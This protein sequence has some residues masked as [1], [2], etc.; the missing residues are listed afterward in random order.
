MTT[1][2][3]SRFAVTVTG[4]GRGRSL[5]TVTGEVGSEAADTFRET[6]TAALDAGSGLDVD[7]S[8]VS[9]C[10]AST[11]RVLTEAFTRARDAGR[12]LA[13]VAVSPPVAGQLEL[14]GATGLLEQRAPQDETDAGP[15]DLLAAVCDALAAEGF[16]ICAPDRPDI[17]GLTVRPGPGGVVVSWADPLDLRA[18]GEL[19]RGHRREGPPRLE[20]IL[21]A[22]HTAVTAA[23][24]HAGFTVEEQPGQRRIVVTGHREP[25]GR[26]GPADHAHDAAGGTHE[27]PGSDGEAT[28]VLG[29]VRDA[30]GA[31]AMIAEASGIIAAT[32]KVG[33]AE[34]RA[35]LVDASRR[36]DVP[37]PHVAELVIRWAATGEISADLR[38][39]LQQGVSVPHV[40]GSPGAA[41]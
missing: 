27:T 30:V 26:P 25:V 35:A 12:T 36:M 11:V 9:S 4:S 5:A 17:S 10:D 31:D 34:G 1:R 6:L 40:D 7:L 16:D 15:D 3:S 39:A 19:V 21:R 13:V 37:V 20:G 24:T 32:S 2:D 8:G 14:R 41:V 22:L 18:R 28:T 29:R 23:L 33:A 38:E